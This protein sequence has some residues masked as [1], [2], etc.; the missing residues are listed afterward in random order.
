MKRYGIRAGKRK[1]FRHTT[2]SRHAYPV[3]A[4]RLERRFT[5]EHPNQRWVSDITYVPTKE[6]WLYLA[7]ILDLF[8]R[9]VVGW[10]M[11][12]TLASTLTLDA[13]HMALRSRAPASGLLHHSDRGV[14]YAC[15]Q[16][17]HDLRDHRI[18]GSMSR[19]GNCWDNAVME[20][21]FGSLKTELIHHNPF[22]TRQEAKTAIFDYLE[23]F[24]NRKRLHSTL[25]YRSPADYEQQH[26][27][28]ISLS[29]KSG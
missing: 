25:G 4:N 24:Y 3:Q 12:K 15:E 7:V 6:G 26:D 5:A 16:Y 8:S 14:Q 1:R 23:V 19:K 21:F 11:K 10:S 17:Q 13:L 29:T 20:S 18:I 28:L 22:Q 9:R 27:S 2:D